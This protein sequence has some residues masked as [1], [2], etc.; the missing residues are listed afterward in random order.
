M[1]AFNVFI[2]FVLYWTCLARPIRRTPKN[3][4]S[5][6]HQLNNDDT[7]RSDEEPVADNQRQF[8]ISKYHKR[9]MRSV[10]QSDDYEDKNVC[11]NIPRKTL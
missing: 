1:N 10:R 11:E 4:F 3:A 6:R 9:P 5:K 8:C 7:K 2:L